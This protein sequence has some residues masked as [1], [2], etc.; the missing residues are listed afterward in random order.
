MKRK[1]CVFDIEVLPNVFICCCRVMGE[2]IITFEISSRKFQ[3]TELV[4]FFTKTNHVFVG[5]NCIH[6]DT[7]I[8]NMLIDRMYELGRDRNYLLPTGEAYKLSNQIINGDPQ[9]WSKWKW[10]EHFDQID[11]M[12][13]MA[14]KALRV[15]LKSLQ[16]TMC[17]HNVQEMHVD[18]SKFLHPSD[19][20]SLI[21]Y[22][23][24]DVGS[25]S[26]L[27]KLFKSDLELRVSIQKNFGIR[28]L[29][30]DGVGIGVDIFT[31]R[32]CAQL[33]LRN[34]RDLFSLR[35]NYEEIVVKDLIPDFI[36]FKTAGGQKVLDFY[37]EM[38]LD[39]EGLKWSTNSERPTSMVCT[40]GKLRHSCGIGGLHSINEPRIVE[41]DADYIIIDADVA[42]LYPSLAIIYR[43]GPAGFKEAFLQVLEDLRSDRLVAKKAKDKLKDTT[44]KLALNSILGNLRNMYSSYYAPEANT[45][46]CVA[47]QLMLLMLIEECELNGIEVISSNTDGITVKCPREK[48][49]LFYEI[50]KRW[51]KLTSLELEYVEYEKIVI[52]AVNDYVA[53]KAGY[54]IEKDGVREYIP[55]YSD[56]KDQIG[57]DSPVDA[58]EFNFTYPRLSK[59]SKTIF[60]NNY[61]KEKGMFITNP[62]LGKGMDCLIISKALIEYFGKGVPVEQ[63]IRG[64]SDI[65]DYIAFQKI[66]RDFKVVWNNEE[67]QHINRYYVSRKGAYLYKRKQAVKWD[68]KTGREYTVTSDSNVLK[69]FGVQLMN[70]WEDK[71]IESYDIDYRY[72]ISK[73]N[74]AIS[75]LEPQQIEL[76]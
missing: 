47:G 70:K 15:G 35:K 38:T 63:T 41:R 6:Y 59:D 72:Y 75:L 73:A 19:N 27:L 12:T 48:E 23:H 57:F 34:E 46:I 68:K 36:K 58:V 61:V 28:C 52:M 17:Y 74:Q 31:R 30:K 4:D 21:F 9:S 1:L 11:L 7:P 69:G 43:F 13:M 45:G 55:G 67:Q 66:G 25:T 2:E 10:R 16:I 56:V 50:S 39:A 64:G 5:Y 71:P 14:S 20:D 32:I 54:W 49:K 3:L 65:W 76:F 22:C 51:E 40:I 24:N 53:F 8:I 44:Y 29:S 33:G 42:S 18:W 37:K 26:E 60:K 62:R